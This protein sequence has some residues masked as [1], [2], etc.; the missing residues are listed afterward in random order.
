[1]KIS[2]KQSFN[3]VNP[4]SKKKLPF[5]K[6]IIYET[7]IS[8]YNKDGMPNAAPMGILLDEENE[9]ILRVF[10]QSDTYKNLLANKICAINLS[11]NPNLYVNATLFQDELKADFFTKHPDFSAPILKSCKENFL[12]LKIIKIES[13]S[14]PNRTLFIGKIVYQKLQ[15][16]ISPVFTRAF[17][18][19]IEILIHVTRVIYYSQIM[20]SNSKEVLELIE[21]INHHSQ[22]ISKV[23]DKNSIY[24]QL[25]R[26]INQKMM[27]ELETTKK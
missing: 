13:D 25:L 6:N 11:N 23:S 22:V 16:Q 12:I 4:M 9:I 3:W 1:M 20:G 2:N 18:S 24:Q 14:L 21:L 19:L 27:K 17:S 7:I 26:K 10:N 15:N 5:E 8:S